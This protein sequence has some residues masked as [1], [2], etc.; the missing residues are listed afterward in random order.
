MLPGEINQETEGVR[1]ISKEMWYVP[2][3]VPNTPVVKQ[4]SLFLD[5]KLITLKS[6]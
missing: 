2:P 5:A 3:M 4:L 6:Q 1:F